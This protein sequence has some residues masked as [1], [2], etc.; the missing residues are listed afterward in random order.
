MLMIFGLIGSLGIFLYGMQL[1]SESLQFA[2]DYKFRNALGALTRNRLVAML[3]GIVV[4]AIFNSS[5][6]TT[7]MLVG[8]VSASLMTVNQSIGVLLG[9]G[10]G[11]A[12]TVQLL[13]F[14]I[15]DYSLLLIGISAILVITSGKN[16]K[17]KH[18]GRALLGFSF[19]FYGMKLMTE[20]MYP[21]RSSEYFRNLL[22]SF[23][24]EPL[25]GV[26]VATVF[27]T[28]IKSSAATIGLLL[29]LAAQGM[30]TLEAAIPLVLGANI[31]S[32]CSTAIFSAFGAT[33]E[34]KRVVVIN[35]LIKILGAFLILPLTPLFSS[36]IATTTVWLRGRLPTPTPFIMCC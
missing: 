15:T 26:L 5:S 8:L 29:S 36:A 12:I 17:L 4:T 3:F 32:S 9:A 21:L 14:N 23:G 31:G 25:L 6:V 7:V 20:A 16:N 28:L 24:E 18:I 13:A 34:G 1:T 22:V 11:T 10:V 33:R 2:T 27:T 19:L 35:I 30:I